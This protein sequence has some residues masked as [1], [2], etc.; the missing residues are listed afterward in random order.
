MDEY[1]ELLFKIVEAN[2]RIEQKVND[3]AEQTS[4]NCKDIEDIKAKPA[5]RWDT[6]VNG[7]IA[8]AVAAVVAI[9]TKDR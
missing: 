7:I 2:G 1:R 6:A 5:R 3:I 4:K 8:A 9:F